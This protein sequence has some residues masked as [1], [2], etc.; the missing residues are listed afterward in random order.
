MGQ[1]YMPIRYPHPTIERNRFYE[2]RI[3]EAAGE[4]AGDA[5]G[6]ANRDTRDAGE[7][8]RDTREAGEPMLIAT[9]P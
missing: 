3:A 5:T 7:A 6:E 1:H 9:M 8:N 4:A 2:V